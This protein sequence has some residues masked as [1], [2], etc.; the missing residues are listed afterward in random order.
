MRPSSLFRELQRALVARLDVTDSPLN[1][2]D[3]AGDDTMSKGEIADSTC[4]FSPPAETP[5]AR[6]TAG[7]NA[8]SEVQLS[9]RMDAEQYALRLGK[10]KEELRYLEHCIYKKRIGTQPVR[11]EAYDV[12]FLR[13][14]RA[15]TK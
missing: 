13:W 9:Q 10:L 12:W 7:P 8:L 4:E 15:V 14:I 11:G 1:A 6:I 3:V 2:P 5:S